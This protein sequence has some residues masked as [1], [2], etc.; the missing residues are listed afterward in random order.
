MRQHQ[1]TGVFDRR[2]AD[3]ICLRGT[4]C[5]VCIRGETS[6]EPAVIRC[7]L[8]IRFLCDFGSAAAGQLI[9]QQTLCAFRAQGT[10][11]GDQAVAQTRDITDSDLCRLID[12]HC[13]MHPA[14]RPGDSQRVIIHHQLTRLSTAQRTIHLTAVFH[15]QFA[16]TQRHQAVCCGRE[17]PGGLLCS[18]TGCAGQ[19][20]RRT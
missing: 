20:D 16:V 15:R 8:S 9:T 1:R 18:G 19:F 6:A 2:T 14:V 4:K 10:R 13:G 12:S 5:T 7:Q 17:F 3:M 11:H